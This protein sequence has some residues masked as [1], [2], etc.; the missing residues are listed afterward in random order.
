MSMLVGLKNIGDSAQSVISRSSGRAKR[1]VCA[2][3]LD[4]EPVETSASI[5]T[6]YERRV[7]TPLQDI[8]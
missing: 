4:P 5:N 6:M 2:C 8:A 3:G 1:S 7:V